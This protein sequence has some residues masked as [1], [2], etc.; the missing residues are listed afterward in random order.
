MGKAGKALKQILDAYEI[1]QK[2]F[3]ETMGVGRSTVH[4]WVNEIRDPLA[5]SIPEILEALEKLNEAAPQEFLKLYL[6]RF[7]Q[8]DRPPENQEL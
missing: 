6:G 8:S 2:R 7:V 3:A 5:D 4:Y 1:N